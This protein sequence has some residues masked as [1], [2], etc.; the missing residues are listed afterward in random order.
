MSDDKGE[1]IL[2]P[3]TELTLS[4]PEPHHMI[5]DEGKKTRE[6]I[7]QTG[8]VDPDTGKVFVDKKSLPHLLATD[9]AGVNKVYN[10]LDND[11]KLEDGERK[12]VS[13]PAVQKEISE[14]ITEPRD[15]IQIER[16]K[17]SEA[18]LRTL[19]D[20]PEIV[21]A[22]ELLESKNRK[23][24]PKVRNKLIKENNITHDECTGQP[25]QENPHAHHIERKADN[26][27]KI[28]DTNNIAIVNDDTHHVI[29]EENIHDEESLLKFSEENGGNLTNRIKNS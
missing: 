22:R 15:T 7:K 1:L 8:H 18:C 20:A 25:L 6:L 23:D 17:D 27:R 12:L 24:F 26:P 16:L 28:L 29:H 5:K 11:D 9:K 13:V 21:H 10:E 4:F 3:A 2:K 14:R 19:R